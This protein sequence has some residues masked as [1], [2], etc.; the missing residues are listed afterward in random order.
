MKKFLK[1]ISTVST[2]SSLVLL[3]AVPSL[4]DAASPQKVAVQQG[5]NPQV[6]QNASVFGDLPG[7]T[8]VTVDIVM[9]IQNKDKLAEF[10]KQTT[11]PGNK[12]YRHYLSVD[13]FRNSYGAD[14]NTIKLATAYLKSFGIQ[15][16][17]PYTGWILE[18]ANLSFCPAKE[19]TTAPIK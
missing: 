10:I 11:T 6:L 19:F 12:N 13:Q 9:K 3:T 8:Q 18:P 16:K 2:I 1:K 5:A 14:S 7:N 15:S 4:T 17:V